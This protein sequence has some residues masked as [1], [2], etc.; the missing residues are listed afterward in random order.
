MISMMS[1]ISAMTPTIKSKVEKPTRRQ[2][3]KVSGKAIHI[4]RKSERVERLR[5]M[6][7]NGQKLTIND[8]IKIN[9]QSR[10]TAV[11]DIAVLCYEGLIS[12]VMIANE[13]SPGHINTKLYS[14]VK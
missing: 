2:P 13:S 1:A 14:A 8:I 10:P 4:A 5:V 11:D 7:R 9:K 3:R 6:F 12:F